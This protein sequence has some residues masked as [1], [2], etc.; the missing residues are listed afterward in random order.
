M[1]EPAKKRKQTPDFHTPL[2]PPSR[3]SCE[4]REAGRARL[5]LRHHP[6]FHSRCV[7]EWFD[8]RK[9]TARTPATGGITRSKAWAAPYQVYLNFYS[10]T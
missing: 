10:K 7:L 8:F 3:S 9:V 6:L 2:S 4:K 1:L 5:R